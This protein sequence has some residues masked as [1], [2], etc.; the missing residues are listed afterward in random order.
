VQ[1]CPAIGIPGGLAL[2]TN[3]GIRLWYPER[4]VTDVPLGNASAVVADASEDLLAYCPDSTCTEMHITDL[5][6]G[7]TVVIPSGGFN[8]WAAGGLT[9][10]FS[11]NGSLLA[12]TT[13][14]GVALADTVTGTSTF[15]GDDLTTEQPLYVAWSPDGSQLYAATYSY[16]Q[17]ETVLA[18][19]DIDAGT[20]E[21][22]RVPFG[23]TLD[24]VVLAPDEAARFLRD[25][26]QP[27]TS[28][29]PVYAQPSGR[30]GV[31]GFRY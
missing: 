19:Y 28:C 27:P 10:R 24:F 3:D 9:A 26:D 25:E 20:L 22:A 5:N 31:C 18:R 6:T 17:S 29:P 2:E 15:I 23:G 11:P 7:D 4:G 14:H 16:G 13:E 8:T 12:L 1:G 21:T 30:T